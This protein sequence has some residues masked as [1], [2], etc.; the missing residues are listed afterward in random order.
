[1]DNNF[2]KHMQ[3]Y[4]EDFKL[5]DYSVE[6]LENMFNTKKNINKSFKE[7]YFSFY[8]DVKSSSLKKQD[9]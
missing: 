2:I 3:K 7:N 6:E 8:D 1:M 4:D 9:W 5:S